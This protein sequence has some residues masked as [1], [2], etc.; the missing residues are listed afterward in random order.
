MASKVVVKELSALAHF[1]TAAAMCWSNVWSACSSPCA[2]ASN[3][4]RKLFS[5]LNGASSDSSN[6]SP[7]SGSF[8]KSPSNSCVKSPSS[9]FKKGTGM[10][11]SANGCGT[12]VPETPAALPPAI[13][14]EDWEKYS[15]KASVLFPSA[16]RKFAWDVVM[17]GLI[18]Y[19]SITV[20]FRMALSFPA[21]GVWWYLEVGVSICFVADFCCNFHTAYL[22]GDQYVIDKVMI[23][24]NYLRGWFLIDFASSLPLE[25][26]SAFIEAVSDEGS[27]NG[28]N[29]MRLLRALRLVRLLRLLRLLKLQRYINILEDSLN[30]NLQF[31]Q[32]AKA[33]G[34]IVYIMHILGCGWFWIA[35]NSTDEVTWLHEYNGGAALEKGV[36]TQYLYSI[37]WAL[38][39]LTTVGFGDVTPMNDVERVYTLV[40]LMLGAF[41]FGFL[42]TTV[43]DLLKNADQNAV[44]I[45]KKLDEVKVYLRWYQFRPELAARVRRYYE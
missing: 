7:S 16:P 6:T 9:S 8:K 31:V 2:A 15:K 25:L 33:L 19:S 34:G 11:M 32:L 41:V 30:V 37:Y 12:L 26:I 35:A 28:Q 4:L 24:D 42:L 40:S 21:E 29:G 36:W 1:I 5:G 38:M 20:P 18:I 13:N 14:E 44:T 17:L 45:E 22:E 3:A 39:I 10:S 43:A 27:E 23:R